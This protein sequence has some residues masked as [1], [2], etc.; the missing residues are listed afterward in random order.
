MDRYSE[1]IL[2]ELLPAEK[3]IAPPVKSAKKKGKEPAHLDHWTPAILLERAAYLR[4]LA[5]FG[6]GQASETLKE[7]PQ[8]KTMLSF[9]SRDGE[10]ELH[11]KFADIFVVLAGQATLVTGGTVAGARTV[12]PGETRGERV[13][14]GVRQ[15][16][17]AG[18]VAHVP[19]GVPH[20]ML[21]AGERTFTAFVVKIE[22]SSSI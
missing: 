5:K 14:G 12:G 16:L 11:E 1:R 15:E 17:R 3:E 20:Q 10:A 19:A 4:K 8:H 7:Y 2:K 13:E 21:V 22:E 6:D 18:D 9:R